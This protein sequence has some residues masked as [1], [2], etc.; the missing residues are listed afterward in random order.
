MVSLAEAIAADKDALADY[1]ATTTELADVTISSAALDE[2]PSRDIVILGDATIPQDNVGYQ[3]REG[4]PSVTGWVI[5]QRPEGGETAIRATR[6][7]AAAYMGAI[8]RAV[9]AINADPVAAGMT[10]LQGS[11]K[12]TTSAMPES[13][14][15]WQ[16]QAARQAQVSF[17]VSWMSH[18]S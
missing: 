18:S 17:T 6:R 16:G 9:K 1:L 12:V 10:A 14:S 2:P 4:R 13:P 15:I 5:V 11:F 8:E 3:T 7:T